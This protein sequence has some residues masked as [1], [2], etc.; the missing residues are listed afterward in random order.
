MSF[1]S[2]ALTILTLVS[3]F[4]I[5]SYTFGQSG[6]SGTINQLSPF[7]VSNGTVRLASTT[8]NFRI[9]SL[10]NLTCLGTSADG[11][12]QFGTCTGGGGGGDSTLFT[13]NSS[14]N[15]ISTDG[16]STTATTGGIKS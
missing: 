7:T 6:G 9:P 5:P 14:T 10:A 4:I 8:A 1:R 16:A 2:I 12:F 13:W 3:V 15:V 11:T